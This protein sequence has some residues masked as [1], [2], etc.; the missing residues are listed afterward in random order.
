MS[1]RARVYVYLPTGG[2]PVLAGQIIVQREGPSAWCRFKYAAD[3]LDRDDAFALDPDLLPLGPE[4]KASVTDFEVFNVFRDSG[5]DHWGRKV[6]ERRLDRS[7]LTELDFL[8][9]AGTQRTGALLY[10][11]N[12]APPPAEAVAFGDLSLLL[13]AAENLERGEPI[14]PEALALLGAGSPLGGMRPKA[15]LEFEGNLWVAKFPS[16]TDRIDQVRMEYAT[17]RLGASAGLRIPEIRL[18]EVADRPV[19]FSARFDRRAAEDGWIRHH[20]LSGLTLTD[21]HERDTTQGSYAELGDWIRRHGAAPNLDLP[22]LFA[23]M[24]FSILI[25][26]TDDHLRNHAVVRDEKGYR[27]SPAYDLVP[28]QQ[29]TGAQRQAIGVGPRG[30]D[31]TRDNALAGAARFGLSNPEAK[32]IHE[33]VHEAVAHWRPV[34]EEAGVQG[35]TLETCARIIDPDR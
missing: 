16:A 25:G 26:N 13:L 33:R 29:S 4:E 21:L 5:P 12:E 8:L 19:L 27:L 15:T 9:A 23:R 10:G 31:A 6:I 30:R 28:Q 35:A 32:E 34:F 17:L 1:D 14:E 2:P 11:I 3:Y 22:E 18:I 24:I 20:V 7:G